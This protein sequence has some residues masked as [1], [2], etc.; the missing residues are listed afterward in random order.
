[1]QELLDIVIQSSGWFLMLILYIFLGIIIGNR[2]ALLWG[3]KDDL[4]WI[5]VGI[6]LSLFVAY[7][8]TFYL[9]YAMKSAP[10]Q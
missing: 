10:V 2:M 3:S 8:A 4:R 9:F 5:G 1:M 6:V 7:P